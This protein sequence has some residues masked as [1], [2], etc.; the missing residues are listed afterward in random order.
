MSADPAL[1]W[2]SPLGN[3]TPDYVDGHRTRG[4]RYS[5]RLLD[6]ATGQRRWSYQTVHDDVWDYDRLGTV[7]SI[8]VPGGGSVPALAQP[9]KQGDIYILDRRTGNLS[10]PPSSAGAG[11]GAGRAL[12]ADPAPSTGFPRRR[13]R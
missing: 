3:A 11:P 6:A 9:T 1:N 12:F 7:R 10:P 4:D 8:P 13:R 5:A 2:C